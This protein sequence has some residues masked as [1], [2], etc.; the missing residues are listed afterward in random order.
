MVFDTGIAVSTSTVFTASYRDSY[1]AL[2]DMLAS[3]H[4]GMCTLNSS[5]RSVR[6]LRLVL[7]KRHCRSS[8]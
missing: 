4:S 5:V 1:G 6:L 2:T 8:R 7:Q 3:A